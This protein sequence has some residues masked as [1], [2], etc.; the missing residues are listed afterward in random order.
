M[1][2]CINSSSGSIALGSFNAPLPNAAR[3]SDDGLLIPCRV[4]GLCWDTVSAVLD[5][6]FTSGT[7]G[8]HELARAKAHYARLTLDN[9]QRMLRFWQVRATT[10][11]VN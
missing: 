6:R 3:S 1:G 11:T 7:M 9:A 2:A 8:P 4:A 10:P 5:S